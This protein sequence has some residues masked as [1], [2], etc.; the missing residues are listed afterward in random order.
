MHQ[1]AIRTDN[2]CNN[3]ETIFRKLKMEWGAICDDGDDERIKH[4]QD[5]EERLKCLL[6]LV[7]CGTNVNDV[8]DHYYYDESLLHLVTRYRGK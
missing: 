2:Y 6:A 4:N 7:K 1:S 3:F 5:I 8:K